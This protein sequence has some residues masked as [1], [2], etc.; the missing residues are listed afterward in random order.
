MRDEELRERLLRT[1]TIY[2]GRIIRVEEAQ[3]ELADGSQAGREL[4]RH[5]GGVA[6]LALDEAGRVSLV[7]QHRIA[8]DQLLL[9][10]PAGK[11]EAGEEPELTARRELEEECGLLAGRIDYLGAFYATP[12]YCDE[13]L[14]LYW[15]QELSPGQ[16]HLD[17]G[18]FLEN[19]SMDFWELHSLVMRGE[20]QDAKTALAVLKVG[21]LLKEQEEAVK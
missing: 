7:R 8:V 1:K 20:I 15:A 18:E 14:H 9:E 4:V 13:A 12:G 10:L 19:S 16:S 17:P 2:S 5:R 11:R 6:V 3:V 21:V